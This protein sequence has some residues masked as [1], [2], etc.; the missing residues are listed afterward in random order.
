[1]NGEPVDAQALKHGDML[2]VLLKGRALNKNRRHQALIVDPL[3]AGL[4]VE[5]PNLAYA[6]YAAELGW[7]DSLSD[8]LYSES[9]DDRF[10]AALDLWPENSEFR[11]AYLVRAVSPGRYRAPPPQVEDMYKPAFRAL[12]NSGWVRI[13]P[14]AGTGVQAVSTAHIGEAR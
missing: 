2:V 4:E 1:M 8:T 13:M 9:L 6:R 10:V 11:V 5:N 12:G 7:L 3:P 14:T